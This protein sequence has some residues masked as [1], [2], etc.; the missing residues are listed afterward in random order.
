M[1]ARQDSTEREVRAL[2]A[3][4]SRV[5]ANQE[6]ASE[7][8]KLRF[9]ALDKGMQ[10]IDA[11]FKQFN[12]Q[13]FKPFVA[14]IEG[15]LTGEIETLQ[16]KQGRETIKAYEVFRDDI[17]DRVEALEDRGDMAKA[18]SAGRSDTLSWGKA[19]ILVAT[20]LAG[21]IIL[22]LTFLQNKP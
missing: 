8:N 6:H 3:T 16:A 7:L 19:A 4:V 11:Q 13:Q 22:F 17:T 12:D 18:R 15:I 20:T 2:S 1:E 14:R 21:Q 9:D 10:S 5:E